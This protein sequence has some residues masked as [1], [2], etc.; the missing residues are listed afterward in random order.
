MHQPPPFPRLNLFQPVPSEAGPDTNRNAFAPPTGGL[1]ST[2]A[3]TAAVVSSGESKQPQAVPVVGPEAPLLTITQQLH[4][5]ETAIVDAGGEISS[6]LEERL[7]AATIV[8]EQKVDA[9]GA[10]LARAA[11]IAEEYGAQADRIQAV[12]KG[13]K[14]LATRLKENLK[15]AMG[16]LGVK[17]LSGSTTRFQLRGSKDSLKIL[18]A[19]KIPKAYFKPVTTMELDREG[20]MND[21]RLDPAAFEG[22]A[23]IEAGSAIYTLAPKKELK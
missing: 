15:Y 20:L 2:T 23:R 13:A 9:Y 17:E 4:A 19:E 10:I 11:S 6:E 3:P 14:A 12:A 18:D 1:D 8:R 16:Q 22:I 21:V 7:S 5:I